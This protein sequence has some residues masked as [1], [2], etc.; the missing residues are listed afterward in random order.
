MI[1]YTNT[2]KSDGMTWTVVSRNE[3]AI[4]YDGRHFFAGRCRP[5][6]MWVLRELDGDVEAAG[7]R[8]IGR[9]PQRFYTE[10]LSGAVRVLC[11]ETRMLNNKLPWL[12]PACFHP[13]IHPTDCGHCGEPFASLVP[14]PSHMG[15]QA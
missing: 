8:E 3:R 10:Q 5:K 4:T 2:V 9:T 6:S 7:R 1:R 15:P 13:S 12:C 14:P 11:D